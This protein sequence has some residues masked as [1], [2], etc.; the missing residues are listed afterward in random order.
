MAG[1][2]KDVK[3]YTVLEGDTAESVAEKFGISVDTVKWANDLRGSNLVVGTEMDILPRDGIL[4]TVK[5]GDTIDKIAEKYKSDAS[6]IT[7]YND[8]ELN[9]LTSGLRIML[10]SGSLPESERPGYVAPVSNS[11]S[12]SS[13]GGGSNLGWGF[14]SG[15]VGNRYA[16]GNCTF[17][18][19]ERRAAIGRPVG[20]F[21]GNANTWARAAG[22]QGYTVNRTP[23]AGAVLVDTA[24]YYGHVGVVESVMPNGDVHITEMNNY[25]YG[26]FNIVNSRVLTPGQ[27]ALYQ[28]IH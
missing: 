17:Y 2:N 12:F 20:S 7:T 8:L 5:E 11:N 26:G 6:L 13:R 22:A 14:R 28:Y 9:G 1:S 25:A 23:L 3:K 10:P 21:W 27:A 4:Y 24:G 18:V 15:S 19:Y 16:F